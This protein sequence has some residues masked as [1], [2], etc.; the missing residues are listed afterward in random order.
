M[1]NNDTNNEMRTRLIN[2]ITN[3]RNDS[4]FS[5]I[6][7][8]NEYHFKIFDNKYDYQFLNQ[9]TDLEKLDLI[10]SVSG[11]AVDFSFPISI[12]SS[13][14]ECIAKLAMSTNSLIITGGTSVGVMKLVGEAI[15]LKTTAHKQSKINLLGIASYERINYNDV[16]NDTENKIYVSIEYALQ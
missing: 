3:N 5:D 11:G 12:K 15:S 4:L 9:W 1:I 14:K 13:F 6:K 8:K 2:S 10:L 7:Q 16:F